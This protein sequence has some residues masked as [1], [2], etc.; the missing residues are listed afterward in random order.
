MPPGKTL[1]AP[2]TLVIWFAMKPPVQDSASARVFPRR[3]SSRTTAASILLLRPGP[4]DVGIE[5]SGDV[6]FGFIR[7][8]QINLPRKMIAG[9]LAEDEPQRVAV[10]NGGL[11]LLVAVLP[12]QHDARRLV[13]VGGDVEG[14]AR[15]G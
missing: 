6:A 5:G 4:A 7:R 13:R 14:L 1:E 10:G 3:P 9:K 15:E 2:G 8:A 12:V 11:Q